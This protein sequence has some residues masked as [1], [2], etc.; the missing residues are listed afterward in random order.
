[1]VRKRIWNITKLTA[2]QYNLGKNDLTQT[3]YG[4]RVSILPALKSN[5][6]RN[7]NS[8]RFSTTRE[9]HDMK[10]TPQNLKG[11]L[12]NEPSQVASGCTKDGACRVSRGPAGCA[13]PGAG[14]A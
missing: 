3:I 13:R 14:R 5:V 4:E 9:N 7:V 10:M 11:H 1:M 8:L 2:I 6:S 12:L